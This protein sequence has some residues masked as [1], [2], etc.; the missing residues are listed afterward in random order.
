MWEFLC[1]V[2]RVTGKL[3]TAIAKMKIE[4]SLNKQPWNY[5]NQPWN[6]TNNPQNKGSGCVI[7]VVF[8]AFLLLL[9]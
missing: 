7:L 3:I 4:D 5:N 8:A 6:Q 2:C 1:S 9:L